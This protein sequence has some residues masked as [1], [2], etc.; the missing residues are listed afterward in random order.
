MQCS[1]RSSP[2][3]RASF[4]KCNGRRAGAFQI[5]PFPH[6]TRAA[7]A[8]VSFELLWRGRGLFPCCVAAVTGV[9]SAPPGVVSACGAA[10]GALLRGV[11]TRLA[12]EGPC[13]LP[14]GEVRASLVGRTCLL[15]RV[16]LP[17]PCRGVSELVGSSRVV[18]ASSRV[19]RGRC[20][21]MSGAVVSA[22]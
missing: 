11:A 7:S 10:W 4:T 8:A 2:P 18:F 22:C 6:D 14:G 1:R 16:G 13:A 21:A 12:H 3:N 15:R 19:S 17:H 9:G 5:L 20:G